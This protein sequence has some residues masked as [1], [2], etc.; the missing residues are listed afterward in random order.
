[1]RRLDWHARFQAEILAAQSREF[2]WGMHDCT[3]F[4]AKVVDAMTDG[5]YA[6]RITRDLP[7]TTEAE[8]LR[9]IEQYGGLRKLVSRYLSQ[10]IPYGWAQEGD[11]VL[12]RDAEGHEVLGICEGVQAICA[13]KTGVA[14]LSMAR[15][16]CAWRIE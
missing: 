12:L 11:V 2:Q 13:F 16:I 5:D 9:L 15:A 10:E 3:L 8:T 6:Q 1:M 4:V 7:H 14:P